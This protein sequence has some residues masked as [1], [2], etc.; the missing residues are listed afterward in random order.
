MINSIERPLLCI[1][2]SVSNIATMLRSNCA[3]ET[4]CQLCP[5]HKANLQ[6]N[7]SRL[8][9]ELYTRPLFHYGV[10]WSLTLI[11]LWNLLILVLCCVAVATLT[12][13]G[14][15]FAHWES[16]FWILYKVYVEGNRSKSETDALTWTSKNFL[17]LCIIPLVAITLSC[18]DLYKYHRRTLRPL[19]IVVHSSVA[20]L[21]WIIAIGL[22]S[23]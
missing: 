23:P 12:V 8:Y 3:S 6:R 2:N 22:W 4:H 14:V 1:D 17:F 18:L 15:G 16:G 21:G 5:C 10:S 7:T 13:A 19:R 11:C 20:F 9:G